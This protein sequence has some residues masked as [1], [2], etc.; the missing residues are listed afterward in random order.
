MPLLLGT[1]GWS[2][3]DWVGPFYKKKTSKFSQYAEI[4]H[5]VEINSTFYRYPS[6]GMIYGLD[7]NAPPGFLF[8]AKL[9]G[10]ITHDKWLDL[11]K[12]TEEDT[13]RFLNLMRP[14]AESL[15]PILIQLRPKFNYK[16][17]IG[18][19]EDYLEVLPTNY[20]WAVEFRDNSWLVPETFSLLSRHNVAYTVVDEPLL[21]PEIHFTADFSYIRWHGR[22]T[23]LWYD[24]DYSEDQLEEWVP[25]VDEIE[26]KTQRTYGY[27]NNHFRAN[28]VKNAIEFLD[29]LDT[30]SPEQKIALDK[31]RNHRE[32]AGRPMGV[33]PL[34]SFQVDD[35]ELSPAD[36]LSRFMDFR[37]LARAEKIKDEEIVLKQV[38][39]NRLEANIRDYYIVVDLDEKVIKHDC[40]DW[41][42]GKSSKRMCKHLGKFFLTL[43][44]GQAKE[45]LGKIW[46]NIDGWVFEE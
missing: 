8:A 9:P 14:L 11:S 13:H 5:T 39:D 35:E 46:E 26:L 10:L 41:R 36:H 30:A 45:V 23:N 7:R 16:E 6:E 40:D 20:E 25:K 19:L 17:H 2:Y 21:P 4:F 22:G 31:I 38:K 34:T 12:G 28:A 37:R 44:P 42:K 33:Q 32:T 1:S 3:D 43:P 18:N 15:G 29:M 24:Y 27:F